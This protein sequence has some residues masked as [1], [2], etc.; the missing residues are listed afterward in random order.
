MLIKKPP[1]VVVLGHIDHGKTTLLDYIRKTNVTAKEAGGITQS[2]GA[3]QIKLKAS[4]AKKIE[5]QITFI[6]TPGHEAF[7]KMRSHGARA[8]DIALLVIAADEGVKPQTIDAIKDIKEA[9]LPFIVVLNKIDKPEA[10]P[11]KVKKELTQ[12][13]VFVEGF[14]GEVPC[15]E[16]SAKTG[17]GV[18]ELL[19]LILLMAE[20]EELK[21]DPEKPASGLVI[22]SRLDSKKGITATLVIQE[23]TLRTGE[24]VKLQ[25][26]Y[27]K[28]RSMDDFTGKHVAGALPSDPV[29]VLGFKELPEVGERFLAVSSQEEASRE[30]LPAA[31]EI[32]PQKL[33]TGEEKTIVK[34]VLKAGEKASLEALSTLLASL[35]SQHPDIALQVISRGVGNISLRDTELAKEFRASILGFGVVI[36]GALK[37]PALQEKVV[38][39]CFPLIYD[40]P[41]IVKEI[42]ASVSKPQGEIKEPSELTVLAI[43][44]KSKEGQV[45][46]GKVTKGAVKKGTLLSIKRDENI[47]GKGKVVNLQHLKKDVTSVEAGKECGI[48]FGGEGEVQVGDILTEN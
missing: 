15:L 45:I 37:V 11:Q 7:S 27:G 13:E 14:G 1:V 30:I 24:W 40:L 38:I 3:Y 2:I 12:H 21:A 36:P 9:K 10:N 44:G 34:L 8:G 4:E 29:G 22:A 31:P 48:L 43:F 20:M 32:L 28:I 39:K 19:E 41:Q 46:G 35:Q 47:V 5:A 18:S 16:I 33:M 42:V 25:T 17:K 26:T 6:D 23:G